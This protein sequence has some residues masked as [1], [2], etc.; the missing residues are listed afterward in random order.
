MKRLLAAVL[1]S[2]APLAASPADNWKSFG[3]TLEPK[4]AH[5]ECV[6]LDKDDARR[7]HWKSD[8]PVDFNVHYHEGSAVSYPVKRDGMRGDGGTFKPK[9]AQDYC[10]MWTARD[11]RAKVEGRVEAKAADAK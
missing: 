2:A 4:Q 8:A 3:V 11:K 10:W 1:A 6:R 5:E 7:W 9:L